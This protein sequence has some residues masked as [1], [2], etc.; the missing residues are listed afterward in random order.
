MV[1][2]TFTI[3]SLD[4]LRCMDGLGHVERISTC[5]Y[6][7][8]L[9]RALNTLIVFVKVVAILCFVDAALDRCEVFGSLL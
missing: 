3:M 4:L 1:V 2:T 9:A 5:L 8:S 6:R 7:R